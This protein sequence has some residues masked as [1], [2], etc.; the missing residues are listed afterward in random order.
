MCRANTNFSPLA[1]LVTGNKTLTLIGIFLISVVFIFSSIVYANENYVKDNLSQKYGF[2]DTSIAE[3]SQY[4]YLRGHWR[5]S[6]KM[7][8]QQGQFE[9]L[10]TTFLLKAFY[11]DD[12]RTFQSVFT[13]E[14]GFFSTDIRSYDVKAKKWRALFLNAKSQR[15][16][17]FESKLVGSGMETI[18]KGGY[19]GK[20]AFDIKAIHTD[21]KADRFTGNIYNSTDKGNTWQQIYI[22][23]FVR[24]PAGKTSDL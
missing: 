7:R 24:Q 9:Q 16:H 8:N 4:K 3:L 21:I 11:H 18:V 14:Q 5:I 12:H 20:E 1:V 19:S 17:Q 22:M 13:S 2:A 23:E 10:K 6:M 15:W